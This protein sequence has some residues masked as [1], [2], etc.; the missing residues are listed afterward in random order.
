MLFLI[1][2]VSILV[3][4]DERDIITYKNPVA[5]SPLIATLLLYLTS[6]YFEIKD[7]IVDML[8]LA[9]FWLFLTLPFAFGNVSIWIVGTIIVLAIEIVVLAGEEE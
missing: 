3:Y 4:F 6:I 2:F 9:L 7:K 1:S 8:I 5:F